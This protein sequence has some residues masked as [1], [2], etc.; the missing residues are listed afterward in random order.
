M[1]L[2]PWYGNDVGG[3]GSG[4]GI[5]CFWWLECV[6]KES[7]WHRCWAS[8]CTPAALQGGNLAG[9]G[10]GAAVDCCCWS[11]QTAASL[12][13]YQRRSRR[14]K[15][16]PS[17]KWMQL[18]S[19]VAVEIQV[20]LKGFCCFYMFLNVRGGVT[21]DCPSMCGRNIPYIISREW[22][23]IIF[24]LKLWLPLKTTTPPL[25]LSGGLPHSV[26]IAAWVWPDPLATAILHS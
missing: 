17:L 16:A 3:V 25:S 10:T 8:M 26:V 11:T 22:D 14:E 6:M 23:I 13:H 5:C 19:N 4:G 9:G 20:K 2:E 7:W 21:G 1:Q 24:W 18:V 12:A 15:F